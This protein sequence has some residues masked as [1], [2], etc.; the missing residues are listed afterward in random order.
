MKKKARTRAGSLAT[1][2]KIVAGEHLNPNG[3]LFG[4]YL[5][6]WMDEIAFMC[7][8]RFTGKPSCVTVNIDNITFRTPIRLGEHIH[9]SAWVNHV[10]K[11]S[12]EIE[13][14]V[15]RENPKTLERT[16][17]NNAHLTFVCLNRK[18]QPVEVPRLSLETIEDQKKNHEALIRAKVRKRLNRF[19]ERKLA[20][21]WSIPSQGAP[22]RA[23]GIKSIREALSGELSKAAVKWKIRA[24]LSN[25]TKIQRPFFRIPISV[26]DR[27]IG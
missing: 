17:T 8:R 12:M 18:L 20:G 27:A 7:A 19:L 10:G 24:G 3:V 14:K 15:E 26:K 22:H 23:T 9:L 4:G 6:C 16:Q 5:M 21:D 13:V 11:T 2:Q 25:L 1:T